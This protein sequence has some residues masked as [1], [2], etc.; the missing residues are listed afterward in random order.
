MTR[1]INDYSEHW[2]VRAQGPGQIQPRW[3][4]IGSTQ[5]EA[6]DDCAKRIMDDR[7]SYREMSH[8]L[9]STMSHNDETRSAMAD[10]RW[11]IMSGRLAITTERE[12]KTVE[13]VESITTV[14]KV[15]V[16]GR[17]HS[18]DRCSIDLEPRETV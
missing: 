7:R 17:L 16:V 6:R 3:I 18:L 5:Q 10:W 8:H 4:G 9:E 13:I 1:T 2:T 15:E 12:T 14:D 11:S